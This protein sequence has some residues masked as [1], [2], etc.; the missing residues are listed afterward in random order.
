MYENSCITL[1]FPSAPVPQQG[2]EENDAKEKLNPMSKI[3]QTQ[4]LL[5]APLS[6]GFGDGMTQGQ[7]AWA[8]RGGALW[9]GV[10]PALAW[11]FSSPDLCGEAD[12]GAG[13]RH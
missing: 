7:V 11:P 8:G 3:R 1:S 4:L 9:G 12:G 2:L 5:S 13:L 10:R 6:P